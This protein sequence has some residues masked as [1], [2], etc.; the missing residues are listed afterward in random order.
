MIAARPPVT[1]A[2][3]PPGASYS[4]PT[5][6]IDTNTAW[7]TFRPFFAAP[8][9]SHPSSRLAHSPLIVLPFSVGGGS[10][11]LG[12]SSGTSRGAPG[13]A[14]DKCLTRSLPIGD[15]N[16]KKSNRPGSK[17]QSRPPAAG[18]MGL[19]G[20]QRLPVV[21]RSPQLP[22]PDLAACGALQ[23]KTARSRTS[24]PGS[25]SAPGHEHRMSSG[26][27]LAI[28]GQPSQSRAAGSEPRSEKR[29]ASPTCC[30]TAKSIPRQARCVA[31]LVSAA[32]HAGFPRN[33]ASPPGPGNGHALEQQRS[34]R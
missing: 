17:P 10:V 6:F 5:T 14:L 32:L 30:S 16:K 27:A 31:Y 25:P 7:E 9:A 8:S 15:K 22:S 13:L 23:K 18:L 34:G 19:F 26:R 28:A 2:L 20:H 4:Y 12:R 33:R 1:Q 11:P 21:R 29:N 3:S 24:Q